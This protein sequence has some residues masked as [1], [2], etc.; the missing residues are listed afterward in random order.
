MLDNFSFSLSAWQVGRGF[1]QQCAGARNDIFQAYHS[2]RFLYVERRERLAPSF[3]SHFITLYLIT[4]PNFMFLPTDT[5]LSICLLVSHHFLSIFFFL[6]TDT[7]LSNHVSHHF[8]SLCLLASTFLSMPPCT[9]LIIF[10]LYV[11]LLLHFYLVTVYLIIFYL[12]VCLL[13]HFYLYH[14][15]SHHFLSQC[16][17]A[18]Y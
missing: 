6:S 5:F 11:C 2:L 14:R 3:Y 9:Y 4:F 17:L 15:V 1:F 13:L 8:L 12:Y 16:L 18:S 10:Y 7:F